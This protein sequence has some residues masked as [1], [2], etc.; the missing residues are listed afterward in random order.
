MGN[1]EWVKHCRD[2]HACPKCHIHYPNRQTLLNHWRETRHLKLCEGLCEGCLLG[3][4]SEHWTEHCREH[5]VCPDMMVHLPAD[6]ECWGCERMFSTF[7][8]MIIHLER[9]SCP[10][11]INAKDLNKSAAMCYQWSHFIYDQ[12]RICLLSRE[13][14]NSCSCTPHPFKCPDCDIGF[15]HL[16]ALFQHVG[17]RSCDQ[18]LD[19]GAIGKL[20][21]WLKNRHA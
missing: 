12:Y 21:H 6:I 10:S 5:H 15:P 4:Q 3:V 16:S 1:D 11:G 17:T 8:G 2:S 13:H 7:S 18:E 9:G 14:D 19:K 20:M